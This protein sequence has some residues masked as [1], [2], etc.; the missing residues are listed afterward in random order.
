MDANSIY[1]FKQESLVKLCLDSDITD[2]HYYKSYQSDPFDATFTSSYTGSEFID[3]A[4][5]S[6]AT[7][8][9]NGF[10]IVGS[11]GR[12]YIGA[13]ESKNGRSVIC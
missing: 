1:T 11:A 8:A 10:A 2:C 7:P 6:T 12:C 13:I 9:F 5:I 3:F 4:G